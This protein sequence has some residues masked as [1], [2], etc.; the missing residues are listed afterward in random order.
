MRADMAQVI[1]ERPRYGSS[2]PSRKKGYRKL[3][4]RTPLD[5]QPHHESMLGRW[6]G[7]S[8]TL[9][10][11]LGPLRRFLRSR[12]GRPWNHVH[13]ELCTYVS[14]D[15]AVQKHIL[16][17]IDQYVCRLTERVGDRLYDV[18]RRW[19]GKGR[20]LRPDELYVDPA[21]GYLQVVKFIHRRRDPLRIILP[22]GIYLRHA[23]TWWQLTVRPLPVDDC[24]CWD[25]WL[26]RSVGRRDELLSRNTYGRAVY[27]TAQR[28][29]N[30]TETRSLI[31]RYQATSPRTRYRRTPHQ[32]AE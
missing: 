19:G 1:I 22:E 21:T 5:E 18:S 10:E 17:H 20:Q 3:Q 15:N 24:E 9:N 31:R 12:V 29:L 25:I 32:V 11:H 2:D 30:P 23:G 16:A 6:Q 27:A 8:K 13:R 4:Q 7:M 26:E 14:F 28:P